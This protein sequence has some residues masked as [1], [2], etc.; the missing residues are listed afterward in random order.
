MESESRDPGEMELP[1]LEALRALREEGFLTIEKSLYEESLDAQ[2]LRLE[3]G[4]EA[5]REQRVRLIRV[6]RG[7]ELYRVHRVAGRAYVD[8][9]PQATVREAKDA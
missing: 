3:R 1:Y 9:T 4:P 5:A 8:E 6:D 2:I 7:V